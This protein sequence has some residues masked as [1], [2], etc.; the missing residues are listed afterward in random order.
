M[1]PKPV[2]T[3]C[4]LNDTFGSGTADEHTV[5]LWFKKSGKGEESLEM[6]SVVASYQKVTMTD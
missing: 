1:G 3:T 6:R 2:E 5:Q 4:S